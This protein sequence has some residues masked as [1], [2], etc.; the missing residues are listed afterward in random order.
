[1]KSGGTDFMEYDDFTKLLKSAEPEHLY[2]ELIQKE[3]KL[4]QT[5]NRVVDYSNKKE[6]QSKEFINMPVKDVARGFMSSMLG[7]FEDLVKMKTLD[8]LIAAMM[9]ADRIIYSG[10]LIIIFSV[11]LYFLDIA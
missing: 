2:E 7:L 10:I 5:L 1:M 8:Q 6:M 9:Q 4:L 11:I 3:D